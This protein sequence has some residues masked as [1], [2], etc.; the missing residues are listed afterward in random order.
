MLINQ[1]TFIF[2]EMLNKKWKGIM[3]Q[4]QI[5]SILL[6]ALIVL[7]VSGCGSSNP[8][9]R[10]GSTEAP[11]KQDYS[12]SGYPDFF[13]NPPTAEDAFYGVGTAKK[14]NPSL[15]KK[16][17]TARARD[18]IAQAV[19][20]KVSTMLK[21]FMQESGVGENAQ[22]LEFTESVS[23]QVASQ[24]LAGSTILKTEVGKM[25]HSMSWCRIR[26]QVLS[27]LP[28]MK[29]RKKKYF[30]MNSRQGRALMRWKKNW[31]N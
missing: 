21:D 9:V 18:E 26:W 6:T 5:A 1:I 7:M 11:A 19:N 2:G 27:M 29:Q 25:A 16:T 24:A 28:L 3:K 22:A 17:A 13:L 20:V 30:I 14:Q 12:T 31:V 4:K 15:A 23:K 8:P 10:S